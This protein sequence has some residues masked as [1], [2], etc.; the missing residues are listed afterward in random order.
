MR[1]GR[2]AA[3]RS[4][5]TTAFEPNAAGIRASAPRNGSGRLFS[6]H[7]FAVVRHFG[8]RCSVH[9][10]CLKQLAVQAARVAESAE[11]GVFTVECLGIVFPM[12]R[13][14]RAKIPD[15]AN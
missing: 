12:R 11:I 4:S 5:D 10:S 1:C 14:S 13:I 3:E 2:A 8:R 6:G 9:R 7:G 15:V